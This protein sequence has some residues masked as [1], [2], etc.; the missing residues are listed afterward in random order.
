VKPLA[1]SNLVKPAARRTDHADCLRSIDDANPFALENGDVTTLATYWLPFDL[2]TEHCNAVIK[3]PEMLGLST[4][5]QGKA[6]IH[7]SPSLKVPQIPRKNVF[8]VI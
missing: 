5:S 1:G 3:I 4:Q 2:R 7:V 6:L 8:S